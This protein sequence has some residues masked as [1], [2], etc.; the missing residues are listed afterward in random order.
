MAETVNI[1]A[2]DSKIVA[3]FYEH[4]NHH[5]HHCRAKLLVQCIGDVDMDMDVEVPDVL[6]PRCYCCCL[7]TT[8][9]ND[10]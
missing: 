7:L 9:I 8:T 1:R 6:V 10:H 3:F 2:H 5:Q 4:Y